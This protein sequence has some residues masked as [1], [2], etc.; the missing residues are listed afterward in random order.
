MSNWKI[1]KSLIDKMPKEHFE[2]CL[3]GSEKVQFDQELLLIIG[4]G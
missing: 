3:L 4:L 2:S 1:L